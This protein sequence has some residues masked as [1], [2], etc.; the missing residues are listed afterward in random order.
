MKL[1]TD[2]KEAPENCSCMSNFTGV[3]VY[4]PEQIWHLQNIVERN[5][6]IE[7]IDAELPDIDDDV[8]FE[9]AQ[10]TVIGEMLR[11][12]PAL[13]A[14]NAEAAEMQC[15]P[16]KRA[17]RRNECRD[18]WYSIVRDYQRDTLGLREEFNKQRIRV[19]AKIERKQ[20]KV[21][22]KAYKKRQV[23]DSIKILAEQGIDA[24]ANLAGNILNGIA[25]VAGSVGGAIA[26]QPGNVYGTYSAP[27]GGFFGTG[28]GFL[29]PN[30]PESNTWL[31]MLL[32]A[33]GLLF[34]I[35]FNR[36]RK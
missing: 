7:V 21:N 17:S 16:I 28:G 23:A 4:T 5:K 27:G 36:K 20:E 13:L 11:D 2:I 10:L 31:F 3:Q 19:E 1:I 18:K 34:F 12:L 32:G 14:I 30:N 29:D 33:A 6:E 8:I 25:N 35:I 9:S 26:G 15:A 22:A 24:R